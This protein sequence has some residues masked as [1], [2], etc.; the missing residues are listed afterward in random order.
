MYPLVNL[1]AAKFSDVNNLEARQG[2]KS[3]FQKAE[4]A[5][6]HFEWEKDYIT[7][8]NLFMAYERAPCPFLRDRFHCNRI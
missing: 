4:A 7:H 1:V 5:K 3:P 6:K 2:V 8:N